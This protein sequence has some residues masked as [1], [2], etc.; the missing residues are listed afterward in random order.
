MV[1]GRVYS[2][3]SMMV[4]SKYMRLSSISMNRSTRRVASLCGT[5]C[6]STY[7]LPLNWFVSTTSVSPSQRPQRAVDH[8]RP[9]AAT[10]HRDDAMLVMHFVRHHECILG[11]HPVTHRVRVRAWHASQTTDDK[12]VE[13]GVLTAHAPFPVPIRP[14][15]IRDRPVGRIDDHASPAAPQGVG[16]L[17]L[18]PLPEQRKGD[19][20]PKEV[21]VEG[22][23]GGPVERV[24]GDPV[25]IG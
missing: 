20:L 14:R 16:R 15:L 2:L 6:M 9:L 17:G 4:A 12:R 10:V 7:V 24:A 8:V 18:D 5:N 23:A 21:D 3:G 13:D 19:D 11:P 1:Q 22:L 25:A